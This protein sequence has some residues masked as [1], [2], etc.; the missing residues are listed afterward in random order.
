MRKADRAVVGAIGLR[1]ICLL[2]SAYMPAG[3]AVAG[4]AGAAFLAREAFFGLFVAFLAPV[5]LAAAFF[6]GLF[7]AFFAPVFLAAAFFFGLFFAAFL[8]AAFFVAIALR[9]LP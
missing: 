5:F 1:N 6:F 8:G 3:R 7:V 4:L 2:S 9:L